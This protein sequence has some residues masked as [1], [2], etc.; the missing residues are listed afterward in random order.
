MS[1]KSV[2]NLT[3]RE[4]LQVQYSTRFTSRESGAQALYPL[5]SMCPPYFAFPQLHQCDWSVGD[6][7]PAPRI[8]V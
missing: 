8:G 3:F 5:S 7:T 6:S 2:C 4:T 1:L